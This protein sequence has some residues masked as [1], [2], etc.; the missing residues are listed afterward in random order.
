MLQDL[1]SKS[2]AGVNAA[3]AG[4]MAALGPLWAGAIYDNVMPGAAYWMGAIVL[5]LAGLVLARV[6][7]PAHVSN[8]ASAQLTAE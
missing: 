5:A 4:L 7:V 8:R 2:L 3:L 1:G 6:R